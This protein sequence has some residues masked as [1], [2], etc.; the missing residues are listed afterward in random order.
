[1]LLNCPEVVSGIY[2]AKMNNI[3][4]NIT[5]AAHDG[6]GAPSL[7][8]V[9]VSPEQ[10]EGMQRAMFDSLSSDVA[11]RKQGE[12]ILQEVAAS[13]ACF[14]ITLKAISATIDTLST[15]SATST[16]TSTTTQLLN[17]RF[18]LVLRTRRTKK[19]PDPFIWLTST[20]DVGL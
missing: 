16:P 18:F 11:I 7:P 10:I 2:P 8:G 19:S 17:L 9:V 6:T 5:S 15:T 14:R 13:P 20:E 3:M 4:M 1:M 12:S